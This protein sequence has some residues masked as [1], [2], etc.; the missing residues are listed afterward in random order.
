M[1]FQGAFEDRIAIRELLETYAD[2]VTR[3]DADAWS[4]CWAD[5]AR[6]SMPDLAI[7]LVGRDTLTSAW[8]EMMAQFHGPAHAPWPFLFVTVPAAMAVAGDRA[9]VRSYT[10]EAYGDGEGGTIHR[11]SE[12]RDVVVRQAGRWWFAERVWRLMP[13]DD[14]LKL[15]EQA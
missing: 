10:M 14:H 3:R 4:D 13:L 2:A 9:D 15:T 11:K 7:E 5:D 1:A 6:W 8:V 12:Y